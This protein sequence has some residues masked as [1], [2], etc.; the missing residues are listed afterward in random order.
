[1]SKYYSEDSEDSEMEYLRRKRSNKRRRRRRKRYDGDRERL[2]LVE[3]RNPSTSSF[4][5][6]ERKAREE[7][8][9]QCFFS[10]VM[11]G[12]MLTGFI[13]LLALYQMRRNR[14]PFRNVR[15]SNAIGSSSS[16]PITEIIDNSIQT[17]SNPQHPVSTFITDM[18]SDAISFPK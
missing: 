15:F 6:Q 3:F 14:Y 11:F 16:S 7:E 5:M 12:T 13:I 8:R 4:E 17:I 1:M 10:G 18:V 2:Q 9:E